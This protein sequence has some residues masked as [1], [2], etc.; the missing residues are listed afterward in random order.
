MWEVIT[1]HGTRVS[2]I[3]NED[4]ARRTLH[5]LGLTHRIGMYDYQV[6]P[7]SGT[8]FTATL[9]HQP[10]HPGARTAMPIYR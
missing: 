10:S 4:T 8:P 3:V 5:M 6:F 9:R 1:S 7:L 2:E